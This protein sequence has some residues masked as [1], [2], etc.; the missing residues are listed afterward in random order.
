MPDRQQ[1]TELQIAV[2]RLLWEQGEL[3]VAQIWEQL[4][5]ERKLAQTTVA[6]IVSRLQRRR[7][8]AR[9]SRDRQFVYRALVTEADVQHSMVSELTERLFAGDVTALV[10]HLLSARDMAPGDLARLKKILK[11]SRPRTGESA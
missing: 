6:T 10:S 4:Y 1:L 3:T 2:L 5:P 8:L 7:I 11:D 9:R